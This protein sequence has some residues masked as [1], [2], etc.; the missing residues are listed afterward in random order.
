MKNLDFDAFGESMEYR[1][2][3]PGRGGRWFLRA[4]MATFWAL[5]AVIVTARAVYFVDYSFDIEK[6]AAL[7]RNLFIWS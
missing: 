6:I 4:G 7:V 3:A 1:A 5:V 2:A